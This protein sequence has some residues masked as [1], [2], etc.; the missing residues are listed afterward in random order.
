[1]AASSIPSPEL[2][3]STEKN[4]DEITVRGTGKITAATADY[5]Q[6]TIRGVIPDTK[7]I[8]LDL[9]GVEYIDSSGLGALVSVYMAAG[10]AQCELELANPKP[11]VRDL[12]KMTKLSTIFEGHQFGGL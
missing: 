11:R 3:L 7:R 5:F 1:M 6:A 4:A 10:R 9:T 8:V 2:E 12:L